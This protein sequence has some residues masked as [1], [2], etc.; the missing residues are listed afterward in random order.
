MVS[1]SR[2]TSL[3]N[4][5]EGRC[6]E[7]AHD[8]LFQAK[9]VFDWVRVAGFVVALLVD[10][11]EGLFGAE[12]GGALG[13]ATSCVK[14]FGTKNWEELESPALKKEEWK[15]LLLPAAMKVP[16]RC[17]AKSSWLSS[18]E[19]PL[20]LLLA[21]ARSWSLSAISRNGAFLFF[22]NRVDAMRSEAS[23]HDHAFLQDLLPA[24]AIQCALNH[25]KSVAC[26]QEICEVSQFSFGRC[27]STKFELVLEQAKGVRLP[28]SVK[29]IQQILGPFLSGVLI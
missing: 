6:V 9:V 28:Q 26:H 16:L 1:Q 20:S 19:L 25:L 10:C 11:I 21:V 2:P 29:K 4:P 5:S 13:R 3:E 15:L 17:V 27:I 24:H 18:S 12:L 23:S 22:T 7:C 14:Q 8:P